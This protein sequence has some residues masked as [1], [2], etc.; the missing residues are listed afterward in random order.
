MMKSSIALA[1]LLFAMTSILSFAQDK[2]QKVDFGKREFESNCASCHGKTGKGDGP[3]KEMLNKS[4]PDLTQLSKKNSGVFPMD[5]LYQV[6]DGA[7][8][9]SHGSRDMPIWGRDYRVQAGEYYMDVPYD[10]EA[11]VRTRILA[12]LE[13]INR[14][15]V[16]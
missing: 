11:Y 1:G 15:Q 16:K 2:G 12:L 3:L 14:L 4:P 9:P 7:N 13:Y 10:P 5:R 6:I 8:V